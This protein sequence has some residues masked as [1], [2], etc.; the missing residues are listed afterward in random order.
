M[1]EI[2]IKIAEFINNPKVKTRCGAAHTVDSFQRD[3]AG[4]VTALVGTV[5]VSMVEGED[6]APQKMLWTSNGNAMSAAP[7]LYDLVEEKP[8]SDLGK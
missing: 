6:P 7:M 1:K 3:G 5:M 2:E 8:I 4:N